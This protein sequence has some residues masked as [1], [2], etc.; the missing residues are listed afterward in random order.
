ME[1]K[2]TPSDAS[3]AQN[4]QRHDLLTILEES[5]ISQQNTNDKGKSQN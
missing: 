5:W 2:R 4:G 1:K 3:E